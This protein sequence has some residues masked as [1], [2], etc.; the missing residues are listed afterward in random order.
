MIAGMV[1]IV[2]LPITLLQHG[3]ASAGTLGGSVSSSVG[4]IFNP[5]QLFWF[6]G[7][8]SWL[9]GHARVLIVLAATAAAAAWWL[10]GRRRGGALGNPLLLLTL[11]LLLRAALDPWNNLY[12]HGPFLLGLIAYEISEGRKPLLTTA[13]SFGLLFI[14]P[15][16]G[17]PHMSWDLRAAVY[18]AVILPTVAAICWKL[19][20]RQPDPERQSSRP[21]IAT[22]F[23]R[24]R[25]DSVSAA[26]SPTTN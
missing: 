13:Y 17:I 23:A 2:M 11:V 26:P 16:T 18:A 7:K 21:Q 12:Y 3:G 24:A 1:G 5:P 4:T 25:S 22:L 19:Y 6:F 15:V 10:R 9:A 8:H 14:V 20:G